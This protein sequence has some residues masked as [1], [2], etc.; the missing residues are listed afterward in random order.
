MHYLYFL[1]STWYVLHMGL[2]KRYIFVLPMGSHCS[3]DTG[4]A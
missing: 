4:C 3:S 1:L 2:S